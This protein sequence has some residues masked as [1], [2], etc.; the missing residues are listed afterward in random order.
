MDVKSISMNCTR[1]EFVG[2]AVLDTIGLVIPGVDSTLLEKMNVGNKYRALGLFSSRTGAAGQFT[3]LDDAVKLLPQDIFEKNI[4]EADILL[5]NNE[6]T[7]A[8]NVAAIQIANLEGVA[9]QQFDHHQNK[10][11]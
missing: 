4:A 8:I 1:P 2:T 5:L 6:V 3:A 7:E 9:M 10:R 11:M